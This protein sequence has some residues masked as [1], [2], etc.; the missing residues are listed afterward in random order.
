MYPADLNHRTVFSEWAA[1]WEHG[2]AFKRE[3]LS[4]NLSNPLGSLEFL[5]MTVQVT[6]ITAPRLRSRTEQLAKIL[7]SLRHDALFLDYSKEIEEYIRMLAEGI[8]YSYVISEI[9]RLKLIPESLTNSWEYCNEPLLKKLPSLKMFNPTLTLRCYSSSS[10]EHLSTQIAIKIMLLTL[11]SIT[12]G[13][14]NPEDWRRL[15]KEESA[16]AKEALEDEADLIAAWASEH[17]KNTCVSRAPRTILGEKLEERRLKVKRIDIDPG[18]KPT[19]IEKLRG[20][21]LHGE[22]SNERI[23]RLVEAHTKYVKQFIIPSTNLDEA[24]ERW[25]SNGGDE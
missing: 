1:R 24:Y 8:T 18:Y 20:E 3:N 25:S 14:I 7:Y 12:T 15:L 9:R 21:V 23:T 4:K 13:K 5:S 22:V 16:L 11:R 10:Y 19:P 2:Y 17:S 6:L